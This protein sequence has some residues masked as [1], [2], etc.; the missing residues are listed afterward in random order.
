MVCITRAAFLLLILAVPNVLSDDEN[1]CSVS[2]LE[3][4]YDVSLDKVYDIRSETEPIAQALFK[5]PLMRE[6]NLWG[7]SSLKRLLYSDHMPVR[8]IHEIVK[9]HL[10]SESEEF[11][12]LLRRLEEQHGT[13]EASR[14]ILESICEAF[15]LTAR[16]QEVLARDSCLIANGK[17]HWVVTQI[18]IAFLELGN[19]RRE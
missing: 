11:Q 2:D 8:R 6:G 9:G 13:Q 19:E 5:G 10:Y 12:N 14:R 16:S 1:K 3:M 17:A 4:Y 7:V 15:D 18:I